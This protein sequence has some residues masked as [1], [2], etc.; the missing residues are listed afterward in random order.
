MEKE[1][2]RFRIEN[3]LMLIA[4][5]FWALGHPLG[6]IIV[7][8]VHPFQ[9]G[10][11]TLAIGFICMLLFC[12]STGRMKQLGK[13]S[14]KTFLL[15]LLLGVFGFFL[16]QIFTFSALKR[17]PASMNAILISS[18]VIF[19]TLLA[20]LFL[21]EK[22]RFLRIVGIFFAA[23]GVVFVIFN[24]GF[25]LESRISIIGCA[26]SIC[27]AIVFSLYSISAKRILEENDPIVIVTIALFSGSL[28]LAILS[29]LTVGLRPLFQVGPRI[30]IMMIILGAGMIGI[31]YPIWFTCLKRLPASHIS[32]YIYIVPVFAVI[33]SLAILRER[34]MWM[35]W[36]GAALVL[37]GIITANVFASRE[38]VEAN[39]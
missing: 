18:N 30:W 3:L 1:T 39:K 12:M 11:V 16:Y 7:E 25:T 32:L 2:F 24:Q 22:I 10:T 33:L 31:S 23:V 6:K 34:F 37:G 9:L 35:F 38:K 5:F 19:I 17:I 29:S 28:L 4:A 14:G 8:K 20:K 13:L 21:K 27:A 15:S 26:F 36:L